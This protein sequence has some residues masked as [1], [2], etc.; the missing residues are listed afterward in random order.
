MAI[1][2]MGS[3]QLWLSTLGLRTA[4]TSSNQSRK[5]EGSR[6]VFLLGE[7]LAAEGCYGRNHCLQM[8]D[9]F[10]GYTGSSVKLV[11]H[12][13]NKQTNKLEKTK[14]TVQERDIQGAR[15]T[16]VYETLKEQSEIIKSKGD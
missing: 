7:V 5:Q 6:G 2:A 9:G 14:Y 3:Q 13:T 4:G 10:Y 12:K 16:C 15:P 8:M 1:T 11:K